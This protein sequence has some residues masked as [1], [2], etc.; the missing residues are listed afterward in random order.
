MTRVG[1]VFFFATAGTAL[2][3]DCRRQSTAGQSI[4]RLSCRFSPIAGD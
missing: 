3:P 2:T 4:H 1:E